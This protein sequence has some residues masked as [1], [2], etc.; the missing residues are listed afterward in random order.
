MYLCLICVDNR[1]TIEG[2]KGSRCFE[3]W[4][5]LIINQLLSVHSPLSRPLTQQTCLRS[6]SLARL[7]RFCLMVWHDSPTILVVSFVRILTAC[8]VS[9]A[10]KRRR[11]TF[12]NLRT[13]CTSS[14]QSSGP[15]HLL[16]AVSLEKV[17]SWS[18]C[19]WKRVSNQNH[20]L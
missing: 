5:L 13:V 4:L 14:L 20:T 9:N 10:L 2:Y 19:C 1:E 7:P 6:W 12:Q 15:E 17:A 3:C 18:H 8:L 11:Y 16:T